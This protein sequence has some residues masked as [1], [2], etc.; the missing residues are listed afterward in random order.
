MLNKALA[1]ADFLKQSLDSVPQVARF[2]R[3][4]DTSAADLDLNASSLIDGRLIL[5]FI[6]APSKPGIGLLGG[7]A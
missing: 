1:I 5:M 2:L 7:D 4:E 6:T 3:S